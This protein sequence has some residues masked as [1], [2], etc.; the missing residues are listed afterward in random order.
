[1]VLTSATSVCPTTVSPV[2]LCAITITITIIII[3][4]T[5]ELVVV[6]MD[7]QGRNSCHCFFLLQK[8]VLE[9]WQLSFYRKGIQKSV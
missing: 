9:P 6:G 7:D 4:M 1:M 8:N 5:C 2:N 3:I